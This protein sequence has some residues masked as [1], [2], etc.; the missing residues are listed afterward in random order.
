MKNSNVQKSYHLSEKKSNKDKENNPGFSKTSI[1]LALDKYDKAVK[2][3]E[4]IE[5][6]AILK[7]N[8]RLNTTGTDDDL[9]IDIQDALG[10]EMSLSL[11]VDNI[12]VTVE[13]EIVTLDGEVYR[14][15]E[16]MTAGNLAAAFAGEDNV[17]NF[18][19]VVNNA[20]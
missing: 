6:L 15:E 12:E 4:D 8:F 16:K 10:R 19:S 5:A 17:N 9:A 20:S 2:D 14:E 11:V 1:G 18:L 7:D 3:S 13:G